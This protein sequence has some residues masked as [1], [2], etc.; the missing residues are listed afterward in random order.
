MPDNS[1]PRDSRS[2]RPVSMKR[3]IE[4]HQIERIAIVT[5]DGVRFT[6]SAYPAPHHPIIAERRQRMFQAAGK[7]DFS[8]KEA[9]EISLKAGAEAIC[10]GT[11]DSID[12]AVAALAKALT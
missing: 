4:C 12:A 2:S 5:H 10:G 8:L 1:N 3:L 11:G 9:E 7:A 6:A